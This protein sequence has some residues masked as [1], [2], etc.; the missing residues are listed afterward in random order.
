M[1]VLATKCMQDRASARVRRAG[2]PCLEGVNSRKEEWKLERNFERD[3]TFEPNRP[4]RKLVLVARAAPQMEVV[5][6]SFLGD[7]GGSQKWRISEKRACCG[8]KQSCAQHY[9]TWLP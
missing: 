9:L 7:P 4:V 1:P 5:K 6:T 2:R 8:Y 3:Q